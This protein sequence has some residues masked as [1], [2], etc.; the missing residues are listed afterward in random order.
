MIT[1][2]P[3]LNNLPAEIAAYQALK[4]ETKLAIIPIIQSKRI[5]RS[6]LDRW[7]NSFNTLGRYLSSKL[8]TKEFIYDFTSAF[9]FIGNINEELLTDNGDNLVEFCAN[10]MDEHNLNYIPCLHYDSPDWYIDSVNNLNKEKVAIRVRVHN[11]ADSL[12]QFVKQRLEQVIQKSLTN[13]NNIILILDFYN[14]VNLGRVQ[15]AIS[16]FS[17]L[18]HSELVIS[19]TSCPNDLSRISPISF[20]EAAPRDDINLFFDLIEQ[21]PNIGYSDYTVRLT[22]EPEETAIINYNTTYLKIIYTAEDYYMVGKSSLNRDDG[23]DNFIDVCQ[24]IVDHD[25]YSG[26]NFSNGDLKISNCANGLTEIRS[27]SAN[28]EIGVNHHIEF[29]VNQ[30]SNIN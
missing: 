30:L 14:N 8:G 20:S 24:Q 21:N 23:V 26:P 28:I 29:V 18:E 4:E 10:N 6:N 25:C 9:E 17:S 2:Y 5:K 11:F 3:I 12:D 27:H 1:Y 22:P 19:L 16:N 7:W 13:T 15:T